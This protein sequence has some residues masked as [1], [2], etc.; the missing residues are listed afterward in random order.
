[1]KRREFLKTGA[2]IVVGTTAAASALIAEASTGDTTP[3]L[4]VFNPH[5]A[6][7][8]FQM[9][10]RIFPHQQIGDAPYS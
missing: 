9:A 2:L 8:L 4:A 10:R 5:E 6:Q 7:T 3:A 1:M